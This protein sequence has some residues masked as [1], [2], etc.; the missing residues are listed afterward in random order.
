MSFFELGTVCHFE[1]REKS[2]QEARQR[3]DFRYGVTCEDFSFVEMTRLHIDLHDQK[4]NPWFQPR[5]RIVNMHEFLRLKPQAM[6]DFDCLA[7]LVI[8]LKYLSEH[9]H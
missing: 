1:R 8:S 4:H 2:S 6:F 7:L 9:F 5:K 3:F